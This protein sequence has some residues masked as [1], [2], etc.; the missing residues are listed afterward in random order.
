MKHVSQTEHGIDELRNVSLKKYMKQYGFILVSM[1]FP[2]SK[3]CDKDMPTA[4]AM[5]Y[6]VQMMFFGL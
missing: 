1:H 6:S 3:V 2:R 4:F 5:K